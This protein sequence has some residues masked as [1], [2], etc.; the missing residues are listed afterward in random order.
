MPNILQINYYCQ[1][2]NVFAK[3]YSP[4]WLFYIFCQTFLLPNF[5]PAKLLSYMVYSHFAALEETGV[6]AIVCWHEF[7]LCFINLCH[8]KDDIYFILS[9]FKLRSLYR[10][11]YSVYLLEKLKQMYPD[12][13]IQLLYDCL[14]FGQAS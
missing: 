2:F 10:I 3:L 6:M 12:H 7:P 4:N 5:C 13:S 8:G 1:Y 11:S 14:C 9:L